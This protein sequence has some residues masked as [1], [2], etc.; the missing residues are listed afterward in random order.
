MPLLHTSPLT[1]LQT[2]GLTRRQ[3]LELGLGAIVGVAVQGSAFAQAPA[4]PK[5]A[6]IRTL[7]KDFAPEELAGCD[8]LS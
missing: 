1:L 7:L 8:A 5:G 6:I 2:R 4:F 3:A